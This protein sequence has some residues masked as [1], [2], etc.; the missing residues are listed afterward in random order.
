MTI[1]GTSTGAFFDRA[2]TGI[3]DLRKQAEALQAQMGSGRKL[4][5]S[6]DDPVAASRLR[7][8]SRAGQLATV[9]G[10]NA[11][12]ASADLKLADAALSA[13]ADIIIRAQELATQAANGTLSGNQ[14]AGIAAELQQIHG[15][16]AALANSRDAAGHALFGGESAGDAYALDGMGNAVLH[17]HRRC[18]RTVAG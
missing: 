15:H 5:R 9:D 6:S 3:A 11:D 1:I 17:R 16:L 18:W 4:T 7:S 8:M 14:R 10:A 12:R 2:R 13:F